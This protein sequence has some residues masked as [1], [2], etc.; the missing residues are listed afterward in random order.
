[1]AGREGPIMGIQQ[2]LVTVTGNLGA[3][4]VS[5]V[6][7]KDVPACSFRVGVTPRYYDANSGQW[8][9]RGTSWIGVC[10]YRALS[11]NVMGSLRKGDPVIVT[12]TLR[13]ERWQKDGVD[14]LSPVIDA[15]AVGPDL[16]QGVSTF[17]RRSGRKPGSVDAPDGA[18]AS[19]VGAPANPL[20]QTGGGQPGVGAGDASMNGV[21]PPVSIDVSRTPGT[22]AGTD[23]GVPRN[24]ADME[25]Q[26]VVDEATGEVA[27]DG[28]DAPPSSMETDTQPT[29]VQAQYG[30]DSIPGASMTGDGG[31]PADG[32]GAEF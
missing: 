3:S 29:G 12:G 20:L 8:R 16:S 6:T 1:M 32:T 15:T 28:V 4:P 9:D 25:T 22:T 19:G 24:T 5:F 21:V 18:N 10:A 30:Q 17:S 13:T 2:A 11:M 27:A 7:G 31:N 14:R 23:M 26:V